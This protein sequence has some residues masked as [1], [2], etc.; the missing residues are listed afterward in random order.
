MRNK[1]TEDC[2]MCCMRECECECNTCETARERRK[3]L[4]SADEFALN[5]GAAMLSSN[6]PQT[7]KQ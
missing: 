7:S 6:S 1:E 5:L 2:R 4:T 3:T